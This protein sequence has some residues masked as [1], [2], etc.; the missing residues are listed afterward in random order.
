MGERTEARWWQ[1]WRRK[2]IDIEKALSRVKSPELRKII[3]S[4]FRKKK[5]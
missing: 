4:D 3:E 1:I 2:P 5:S